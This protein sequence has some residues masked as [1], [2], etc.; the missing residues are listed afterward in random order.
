MKPY[1]INQDRFP[2]GLDREL[3]GLFYDLP[4]NPCP[5]ASVAQAVGR[6]VEVILEGLRTG[7]ER[8]TFQFCRGLF[9]SPRLGYQSTLLAAQVPTD[10]VDATARIVSDS[11]FVS[12]NFL[13]AGSELNLWFTL[14]CPRKGPGLDDVVREM[15]Q[16]LSLPLRRFDAVRHYKI[17]FQ[18]LFPRRTVPNDQP[19]DSNLPEP[20]PEVLVRAVDIL[21]Q[22][23][24]L[25]ERPFLNRELPEHELLHA[26]RCLRRRGVL[27]RLG[28][29]W[30]L[31]KMTDFQNLL[32][33]WD[34]P[35]PRLE[36]FARAVAEHPRV[37]HCYQRMRLPDWPWSLYTVFHGRSR[38][39]GLAWVRE[40]TA[41]FPEARSLPLW[42]VREYKQSPIHYDPDKIVLG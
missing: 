28:V 24:P 33:L 38:D 31:E 29:V 20:A 37:S 5:W 32:C 21:Q 3:M 9:N 11:L 42:T 35:E 12:H 7:L 39:D 40:T 10:R 22:D 14:T 41:N 8:G 17:S 13:R 19:D 2:A 16:T 30:N 27:R 6:P 15:T 18:S 1:A 4:L 36:P 26:A 34:L 25:V 23:L